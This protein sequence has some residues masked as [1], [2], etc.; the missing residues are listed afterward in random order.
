MSDLLTY[1]NSKQENEE[2]FNSSLPNYITDNLNPAF[3][4]RNYQQEALNRLIFYLNEYKKR[5]KPS[6]LLFQMATG[7]GKTLVMAGCILQLFKQGYR[8][9]IFFVNS[10]NIIEKTKDNFLNSLSGKYLFNKQIQFSDKTVVVKPVENFAFVDENNINI[11]FTTIQ[12]LHSNLNTP[13][14]NSL[15]YEDFENQKIVLLS[16]EAHHLN[17]DVLRKKSGK[18]TSMSEF[19]DNWEQ[20]VMRIFKS[21]SENILLEFTAT[22]R[23]NETEIA[24]KYDDKLLFDYSLKDL[25]L[26]KYSKEVMIL[27]ADLSRIDRALQTVILSQ[28]RLLLF[29]KEK[30]RIKPVIMFKSNYVNIPKKRDENTVVS[31]EFKKEFL[32]KIANLQVKDLENIRNNAPEKS[33]IKTAF[34]FFAVNGTTLG[35]LILQLKED[36]SEDKVISVDS[37]TDK[38]ST[39]LIVNSLEEP[40]NAVRVIFAVD[41]LN[42]GWDVLNLF[43]IVRLYNTRDSKGDILGKATM[44]EAQLI[45]R[46]ARYCPFQ[47]NDSQP[48]FQRKF[49]DDITNPLR[50]CEQLYFHSET[51]SRYINE[52]NKALDKIG[53]KPSNSVI[54][55]HFLKE[56]FKNSHFYQYGIIYLNS[57]ERY[58]NEETYEFS[59]HLKNKTFHFDVKRSFVEEKKLLTNENNDATYEFLNSQNAKVNFLGISVLRKASQRLSFYVF[60]NLLKYFPHLTSLN[61]FFSSE[62]YLAACELNISG[63]TK[64]I[65]SMSQDEKLKCALKILQEIQPDI[66]K[67]NVEHKGTHKFSPYGISK[68]FIDKEMNFV[69]SENGDA[70]RGF[71]MSN[72]KKREHFLNLTTENWY[73]FKENFG[74]SEEKKLIL[75]IKSVIEKL[76]TKYREV[77]LL[78]NEKYF[79]IYRFSDGKAFEPDFV[80]F[81]K[82]SESSEILTFQLFIEPKGEVFAESDKWKEDFLAEIEGKYVIDENSD[83]KLIGLPFFNNKTE[84]KRLF[85]DSFEKYL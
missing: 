34:T 76:K 54:R 19:A 29:A 75:F 65:F 21:N 57:R 47:L 43:D 35:N 20:T 3:E 72:P 24:E 6:Q 48:K 10:T 68:V 41:A 42:E 52:L 17:V 5:V 22:A 53:I 67:G 18:Q 23:L 44:S 74:T 2:Y 26:A 61:E 1:L 83:Y 58:R 46:G 55:Q 85:I 14:E 84:K 59:E 7:S 56:E 13:K 33:I 66:E 63:D 69:L 28:Y 37:N 62:K 71:P 60:S 79:Q 77:F 27:Q 4:I 39:Q 38:Q 15:T 16:D 32:E 70:E 73:A 30:L 64:N 31:S 8:N 11:H 78:R 51:N 12:S 36:F 9:F 80:L 45:G 50:I 49:D 40:A 82:K 25:F 81:L